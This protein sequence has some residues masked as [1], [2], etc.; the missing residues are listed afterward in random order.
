MNSGL[1]LGT[2]ATVTTMGAAGV[3][4]GAIAIPTNAQGGEPERVLLSADGDCQFLPAFDTTG[5]GPIETLAGDVLLAI[6][7]GV[8][9]NAANP[10]IIRTKGF[11]H[12]YFLGITGAEKVYMAAL[13]D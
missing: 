2:D 3:S 7:R 11:S 1:S 13:E 8:F 12:F 9:L 4:S 6:G 5:A 10:L